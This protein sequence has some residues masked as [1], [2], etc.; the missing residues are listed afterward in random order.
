[1]QAVCADDQIELAGRAMIEAHQHAVATRRNTRNRVAEKCL[2]F[3]V[4]RT[5]QARGK[6]GTPKTREA[7]LG[8]PA[9][10]FRRKA[11]ALV[12]TPVDEPDFP[13]LI[14][15]LPDLREQPVGSTD[16]CNTTL[17]LSAGV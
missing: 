1:M 11:T 17:S 8:Q 12:A 3:S 15:Q 6:I 10:D 2:D 13:H 7:V 14:A 4:Q 5:V 9:K 16:H